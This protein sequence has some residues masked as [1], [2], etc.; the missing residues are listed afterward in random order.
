[1]QLQASR[2]TYTSRAPCPLFSRENA[3]ND[4]EKPAF[5]FDSAD[6]AAA[7]QAVYAELKRVARS[8]LRSQSGLT[9]LPATVL[10]HESYA[11]MAKLDSTLSRE[12]FFSYAARAM[13]SVV[14]DYVRARQTGKR[15]G[16]EVSL[17]LAG[18]VAASTLNHDQILAVDGALRELRDIDQRA[19]DLVE[20]RYFAGFT[21]EECAEQLGI[22][23]A[24]ATRDW[25]K[26]R[27]FLAAALAE[28][29]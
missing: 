4:S 22:S 25:Q 21:L 26:A 5:K 23:M 12:A 10:V 27:A 14:V 7:Y 1:M 3:L 24:T 16:I 11:R 28:S 2:L 20:L 29:Q 15:D 9:D 17:T 8:Q 18:D 19:H 6:P 13:R